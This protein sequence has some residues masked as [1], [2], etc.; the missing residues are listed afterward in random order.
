MFP[1]LHAVARKYPQMPPLDPCSSPAAAVM[2]MLSAWQ[3]H[4]LGVLAAQVIP[5][6]EGQ[7][8]L[9]HHFKPLQKAEC[10]SLRVDVLPSHQSTI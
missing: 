6:W 7:C 4:Q 10:L 5:D 3:L 9:L 2:V 1:A 8:A